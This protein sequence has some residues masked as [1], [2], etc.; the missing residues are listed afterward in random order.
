MGIIFVRNGIYYSVAL[1][2]DMMGVFG[3]VFGQHYFRVKLCIKMI[4]LL[5]EWK[6]YIQYEVAAVVF[7]PAHPTTETTLTY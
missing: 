3:Q 7:P 4:L 6:A 1:C 5:F 2:F